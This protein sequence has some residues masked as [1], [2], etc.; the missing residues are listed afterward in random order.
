MVH[1]LYIGDSFRPRNQEI[2]KRISQINISKYSE[3][4]FSLIFLCQDCVV[5]GSNE[6]II[7]IK[8]IFKC[9]FWVLK[10]F[11]IRNVQMKK[12]VICYLF[13]GIMTACNNFWQSNTFSGRPPFKQ[14]NLVLN[15][16]KTYA[17][18]NARIYF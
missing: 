12:M 17:F 15:C 14:R 9:K 7:D 18:L 13:T 10:V 16:W 8:R 2:Q 11:N 6:G 4:G 1:S 5:L 3:G